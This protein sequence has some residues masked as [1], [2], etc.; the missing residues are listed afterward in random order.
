[1][2]TKSKISPKAGEW[3][4]TEKGGV[5]G[6]LRRYNDGDKYS[7]ETDEGYWEASGKCIQGGETED[8]YGSLTHRCNPDGTRYDPKKNFSATSRIVLNI[9]DLQ[10]QLRAAKRLAIRMSKA[11]TIKE[12]RA[13]YAKAVKK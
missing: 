2:A 1:M 12:A 13:I 5:V 11:P 7:Y 10:K 4:M 6:P 8:G 3:W 9:N